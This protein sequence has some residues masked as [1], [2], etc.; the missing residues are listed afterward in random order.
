MSLS[1]Q[2]NERCTADS[3]AG[4]RL[5]RPR[6]D[7]KQQIACLY[8]GAT[9]TLTL[10]SAGGQEDLKTPVAS[11]SVPTPS[12]VAT[13]IVDVARRVADWQLFSGRSWVMATKE[14]RVWKNDE[15]GATALWVGVL[16]LYKVT[17]EQRYLSAL[18]AMG[19]STEWK[20][21]QTS[22][23]ADF[24]SIGQVYLDLYELNPQ[25]KMIEP[26][27]A[28]MDSMVARSEAPVLDISEPGA[29]A[30]WSWSDALFMS[31]PV[32]CHLTA[33]TGDRKYFEYA[34]RHWWLLSDLL[35][36]ADEGLM[37]RD[38]L[39]RK[40]VSANGTKVFWS[41]ANGWVFASLTRILPLIPKE[42]PNRPRYEK[43]FRHMAQRLVAIQGANGLWTPSLL[44]R[45]AFPQNETSGSAFFCYGLA[46][47]LNHGLLN[48]VKYQRATEKAWAG[49]VDNVKPD[50]RFIG[51]QPVGSTPVA[52]DPETTDIFGVG[53]FLMAA[54]EVK[55]LAEPV[56]HSQSK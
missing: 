38:V 14:P 48:G 24:H 49:L 45:T 23:N 25:P 53:A 22:F 46:W 37:F 6:G 19:K 28:L 11:S 33:L 56:A 29:K 17:H 54:S 4:L 20:P 35:Y 1:Q 16:E 26:I 21:Q 10:A 52:F 30:W 51:V 50:G 18:M 13:Q 9:I 47:G 15:W 39:A 43:L 42:A 5:K 32:L 40:N 36:D 3:R 41:R 34:D 2:C 8:V 27:R 31:P 7:I 44:D 55:T 12:L